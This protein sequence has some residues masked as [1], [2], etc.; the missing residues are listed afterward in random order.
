MTRLA[1]IILAGFA[2]LS[3]LA[4]GGDVFVEG[5]DDL[6]QPPARDAGWFQVSQ[7][8]PGAQVQSG[9]WG[10][11]NLREFEHCVVLEREG[12]CRLE[13]CNPRWLEEERCNGERWSAGE[14]VDVGELTLTGGLADLTA[15]YDAPTGQY[16]ALVSAPVFEPGDLL[17]L[18][19]SGN[20]R[21]P[22][23]SVMLEGP[24][25]A[26][27]S[28][29]L[30]LHE[31]ERGD[32]IKLNWSSGPGSGT[33]FAYVVNRPESR[34]HDNVIDSGS[35]T[36]SVICEADVSAGSLVMP[37]NL[38][39]RLT[40]DTAMRALLI[41][42]VANGDT[43][44]IEGWHLGFSARSWAADPEGGRYSVEFTVR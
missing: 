39:A 41:V 21:V 6:G 42:D 32:P 35:A 15:T 24:P 22:A 28:E 12:S 8:P 1:S 40:P 13:Y 33:V 26:V 11:F 16:S 2:A 9:I 36:E 31:L 30:E 29:P 43:V 17:R 37:A 10:Y 19:V 38:L 5:C 27:I 18:G 4:C 14:S 44:T 23:V 3:T 20:A 25:M 34:Q 7:V